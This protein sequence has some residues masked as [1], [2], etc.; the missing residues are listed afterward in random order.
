M[1]LSNIVDLIEETVDEV[2]NFSDPFLDELLAKWEAKDIALK[3]PPVIVPKEVSK[4]PP[5]IVYDISGDSESDQDV[6]K[7][8]E[9]KREQ[10]RKKI[11]PQVAAHSSNANIKNV[12]IKKRPIQ[13]VAE[14]YYDLFESQP[15]VVKC[16]E[17]SKD[18][19]RRKKMSDERERIR[20]LELEKDRITA[21]Q[22]NTA[23]LKEKEIRRKK[24]YLR[25]GEEFNIK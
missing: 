20:K 25:I 9:L 14:Y 23:D 13:S 21:I 15:K 19:E 7:K 5:I 12:N 2:D 10:E 1:D 8:K 16:V 4:N 17:T 22:K 11:V 18:K 6:P 24:Y 3:N